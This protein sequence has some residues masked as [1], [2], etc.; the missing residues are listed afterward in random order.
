MAPAGQE[1]PPDGRVSSRERRGPR[2]CQVSSAC[3]TTWQTKGPGE[4]VRSQGPD[5]FR[6]VAWTPMR[7]SIFFPAGHCLSLCF[8]MTAV[9]WFFAGRCVGCSPFFGA[10]R[11]LTLVTVTLTLADALWLLTLW[12]TLGEGPSQERNPGRGGGGPEPNHQFGHNVLHPRRR[13]REHPRPRPTAEDEGQPKP[14]W[15]D[16]ASTSR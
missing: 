5:C 15:C 3:A 1:Q 6:G 2:G 14:T 4:A 9:R 13:P 16:G 8:C 10:G 11:M 12:G 7:I